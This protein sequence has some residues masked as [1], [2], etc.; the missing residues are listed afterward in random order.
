[1]SIKLQSNQPEWV[2]KGDMFVADDPV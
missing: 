1:M 2:G